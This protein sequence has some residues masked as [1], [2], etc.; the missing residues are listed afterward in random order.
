[1]E[2]TSYLGPDGEV[3]HKSKTSLV[4]PLTPADLSYNIWLKEIT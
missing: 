1:M 4:P 3:K 2:P